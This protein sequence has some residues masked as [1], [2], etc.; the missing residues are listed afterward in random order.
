[1]EPT[2]D[3]PTVQSSEQIDAVNGDR[4]RRTLV[5]SVVALLVGAKLA[6]LLHEV[7]HW[8]TGAVLGHPSQLYSYAVEHTGTMTPADEATAVLAGPVLS[9]LLGLLLTTWLPLRHT[10]GVWHLVWLWTGFASLQEGV[11]YLVIT[12]VGA[13]DTAAAAEVLG[14]HPVIIIGLGVVGIAGMFWQARRFAVHMMRHCGHD[15]GLAWRFAF[16][17]WIVGSAIL[18]VIQLIDLAIGPGSTSVA[19]NVIIVFASISITVF[20]PMGFI[21]W[22]RAKAEHEP[23]VLP[24]W[25]VGPTVLLVVLLVTNIVLLLTGPTLG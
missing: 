15:R 2:P 7:A 22:S 6:V 5:A 23:L 10:A 8:V 11:T 16:I 18:V 24:S 21:F 20:A 19:E 1:M 4:Q 9:I 12:P 3:S 17:P 25:P 13:G 14:W